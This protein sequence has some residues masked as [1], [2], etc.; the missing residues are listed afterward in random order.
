VV[1][2]TP[3]PS[4]EAKPGSDRITQ[5]RPKPV[6]AGRPRS[7]DE[8]EDDEV[9]PRRR[10]RKQE[11]AGLSPILWIA[12][13]SSV[14]LL[15]AVV[16]GIF[17][18]ITVNA[19]PPPRQPD[20]LAKANPV[21][22]QVP[23]DEPAPR[24]E[25]EPAVMP[26]PPAE[27]KIEPEAPVRPVAL[28]GEQIYDK[29]L[30]STVWILATQP[31]GV[32]FTLYKN[33]NAGPGGRQMPPGGGRGGA[34]PPGFG[35]QFQGQPGAGSLAGTQWAGTE[36]NPNSST[37]KLKILFLS[38]TRVIMD[39]GKESIPGTWSQ[40]GTD[41][42]IKLFNGEITY[43]GQANGSRMNGNA[44]SG[45][46]S[47]T[48]SVTEQTGDEFKVNIVL[49][50]T[51]T[52]SLVDRKHRLILTNVHVVGDAQ[53]VVIHFPEH[54]GSELMVRR[55]AY[56][57]MTGMTGRVVLRE[58]RCDLALVQLDRLPESAR[59]LPLARASARPAQQVHSVG[60]PGISSA[61]WCYSPGK[62]R[63]V[64]RDKWESGGSEVGQKPNQYEGMVLQTDSPINPGDSGGP[65]VNDRGVLVGVAHAIHASA[66]NFSTFIDVSEARSL[67]SRYYGK[68]G[69]TWVPEPEPVDRADVA[70]LSDWIKMLG[71]AEAGKRAE[72]AEALGKMGEAANLAFGPL[73]AGLKDSDALVRRAV[74]DALQKVPPHK[75]DVPLL[76]KAV[77]D[78]GEP[79]LVRL[80]AAKSLQKLGPEARSALA[81]LAALLKE[82]DED[83]VRAAMAALLTIGPGEGEVVA[84]AG[85]L[86]H[87]NA[88]VRG[89]AMQALAKMGPDAKAAVPQLT[90]SLKAND[91]QTRRE[92]AKALSAL[93]AAAKDSAKALTDALKDARVDVG[94]ESAL[95]LV[96]LGEPRPGVA[97][98]ADTLKKGFASPDERLTCVQALAQIGAPAAAAVPALTTALDDERLREEAGTA[99]AKMGKAAVGSLQKK[100]VSSPDAKVRLVCITSLGQIAAEGGLTAA[101]QRDV[102]VVLQTVALRD[103]VAENR[104]AAN[105][106]VNQI[107]GKR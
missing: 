92:A 22:P 8:D 67:L 34:P 61:L 95:A 64:F 17:W 78:A 85:A 3:P 24:A 100:L 63:Q 35:G 73:F 5:S 46:D 77:A 107:Q 106:V 72:A 65:L 43:T 11:A 104:N 36:T 15:V 83:L 80:Q 76:G 38:Q 30:K 10:P 37:G 82:A 58:D 47:W 87:A 81:R 74:S 25:Q 2:G 9:A 93:G 66:Q 90:A 71:H 42:T 86:K 62:V 102:L 12:G 59:V 51:G 94:V 54:K 53:T 99:L 89:L 33:K 14:L 16:G 44:R 13:G 101:T 57:R 96:K 18:F 27:Q 56:K 79:A 39:D 19:P 20:P 69:E 55:D 49:S 7:R 97:F 21:L 28:G 98:L 41:V 50:Q 4:R 32:S 26:D 88:E 48:W 105:R 45:P 70:Q 91:A 40:K 31:K 6:P 52:G 75:D 1:G 68:R 84:L 29:V 60:N 103:L 23:L